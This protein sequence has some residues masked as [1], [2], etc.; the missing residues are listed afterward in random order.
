[1]APRGRHPHNKLTDLVLRHLPVGRHADGNGLYCRVRPSGS[2]A[3]VQRLVVDGERKE[4]GLGGY[5]LV[6]LAEARA[7]ALENRRIA[8]AGGDPWEK[9]A[10]EAA[11]IAVTL[12]DVVEDVIQARRVNWKTDATERAWRRGF[13]EHVF[14]SIGD[15]PVDQVTLRDVREIVVP[16]WKGRGSLGYVLRQRLAHVFQWAIVHQYRTDNPAAQLQSIL[17]KIKASRQHH[18]SLPHGQVR[19]VMARAAAADVDPAVHSALLFLVLC[20]SR[21][22]EVTGAC[23]SEFDVPGRVWT[24]PP[25]RMKNQ[26][27]HRIPL[28]DQA[29]AVLERLR[30]LGRS[31]T[32]VFAMRSGSGRVTPVP[33]EPV[34]NLVRSM[35]LVD[36]QSRPVV[37]HGF[38]STFRV[39]AVE[40]AQAPFEVCEAALAHVQTDQTIAAYARTDLFELRRRLMQRWADYVVPADGAG[41]SDPTSGP[42]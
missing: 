9:R 18:P 5:P 1:M 35:A 38:R 16:H 23:W 32:S 19:E 37:L 15:K 8:R 24:L 3:W 26:R 25:E 40:E 29:V 33:R 11:A 17:P 31:E 21:I 20:A 36:E 41:C 10:A 30:D 27:L 34:A 2:R 13:D 7:T 12:R 39:W 14:P 4:R 22:G 42:T 28:S 6:S